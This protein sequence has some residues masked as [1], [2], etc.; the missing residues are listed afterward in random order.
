MTKLA[1]IEKRYNEL[2]DLMAQP[3]ISTDFEQIKTLSQEQSS[4][5]DLV[6]KFRD[7]RTTQQNLEEAQQMLDETS[8]DEMAELAKE[9]IETLKEK[10]E[11]LLYD[12]KV[13]LLP[14]D[15][16]DKKDV[17]VEIRA[18]A[19]GDEAALFAADLYRA[20]SR[21]AINRKWKV[22]LINSNESGIGGFKEIVFGIKGK[23]A[24]SRLKYESGVHRVQRVPS[25][26]SSGRLH[27]STATV[28]VLPEADEV[29]IAINMED[30]RIDT[31]RASGAG[32]QHVNKTSSAIRIT[33]V[34]TGI[35]STCQDERSQ[36]KNKN[37][38]MSVLRTRLYDIE[39][40]KQQDKMT[41]TRRS[42]V[43]N[44]DR[45]EKIRTYNFPQDRVTDHRIGITVHNL[46]GILEGE[47]DQLIDTVAT[48]MQA[49]QLEESLA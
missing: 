35:V 8:D 23:G 46:P 29:D 39:L 36:L 9:E 28:A 4:I 32:G 22:E 19:G 33:H 25:T 7:L 10:N 41:S 6:N 38:A 17:I 12:I 26:E 15:P 13:S 34:P 49:K 21:Y 11:S 47:L 2:G 27:T 31:F 40:A 24:Y 18:G 30:L 14:K 3:E 37:K 43:G 44:A 5:E 1:G 20:Y 48:A 42:Q 45:S 16:A